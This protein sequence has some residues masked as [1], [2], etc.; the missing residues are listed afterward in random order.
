VVA[1]KNYVGR[2]DVESAF[3]S[4]WT[5]PNPADTMVGTLRDDDGDEYIVTAMGAVLRIGGNSDD[6]AE[7]TAPTTP[8]IQGVA[9]AAIP[10]R[11]TENPTVRGINTLQ[12]WTP[13][14]AV[15]GVAVS[16][17]QSLTRQKPWIP[18]PL[19][20]SSSWGGSGLS[21]RPADL[22]SA[23][24]QWDWNTDDISLEVRVDGGLTRIG[25]LADVELSGSAPLRPNG[26]G[27]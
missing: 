24:S 5:L 22:W 25:P 18:V 8:D 16:G 2:L 7:A 20:G 12:A 9:F 26:R 23:R 13:L 1:W 27:N 6:T 14:H 4:W 17:G 21:W 19:V 3:S 11:P 15:N 10:T